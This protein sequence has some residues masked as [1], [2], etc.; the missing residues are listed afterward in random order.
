[1]TAAA[2]GITLNP[3]Q[4][5]ALQQ[6]LDPKDVN[7]R[8]S[9]W[10]IFTEF[11]KTKDTPKILNYGVLWSAQV[12]PDLPSGV[13]NFGAFGGD[14]KNFMSITEVPGKTAELGEA[15][16]KACREPSLANGRNIIKKGSEFTNSVCDG[17]KLVAMRVVG[18]TVKPVD[19]I[20]FGATVIGCSN[21]AIED[22][23]KISKLPDMNSPQTWVFLLNLGM[24][25]SYI[26]VGVLGLSCLA[27]GVA[28]PLAMLALLTSGLLFSIGGF[29]GERMV[30]PAKSQDLEKANAQLHAKLHNAH[31]IVSHPAVAV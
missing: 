23:Q 15:L 11:L 20:S 19:A 29:F 8:K 21:S 2:R 1:M 26:S 17:I 13:K 24:H 6:V 12:M 27:L 7:C 28:P 22:V 18:T 30:D 4:G 3:T 16:V 5:A 10:Q 31:R 9:M 25:L 14:V